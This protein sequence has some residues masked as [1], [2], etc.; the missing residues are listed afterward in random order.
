MSLL[1]SDI[2]AYLV[3]SGW[4]ANHSCDVSTLQVVQLGIFQNCWQHGKLTSCDRPI[5]YRDYNDA[6][7]KQLSVVLGGTVHLPCMADWL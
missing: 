2:W 3:V 5:S 6:V 1:L 4:P 7:T